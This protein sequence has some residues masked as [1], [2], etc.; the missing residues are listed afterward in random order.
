MS[1]FFLCLDTRVTNLILEI[2]SQYFIQSDQKET[3]VKKEDRLIIA[4]DK[5]KS[6]R[7][8]KNLFQN[9]K[10][11]VLIIGDLIDFDVA[12]FELIIE[13]INNANFAKLKTFNGIY[14]IVVYNKS[15][16]KL[17]ILSDR[18]GFFP[19]FYY[20]KDDFL[21]I[22]SELS[23]FCKIL[24]NIKVNKKW[25]YQYMYFGFAVNESTFLDDVKRLPASSILIYDL[26]SKKNTIKDYIE[27]F[28]KKEHLLKGIESY[29]FAKEI[30]QDRIS[31]YFGSGK[32]F[33]C[34]LTGGWDGRTNIAL[35]PEGKNITAYTYGMMGSEDM[36]IASLVANK[37]NL[38]HIKI[39]FDDNVAESLPNLM[40][41]TVYRSQGLERVL[42]AYLIYVY[43]ILSDFPMIISGVGYDGLFRGHLGIA[44]QYSPFVGNTFRTGKIDLGA[45]YYCEIFQG[46]L[47]EFNNEINKC[48]SI[49]KNKFG[50]FQSTE[51]HLL[52]S[53]YISGTRYFLG[54]WKL[55]NSFSNFRAPSYDN[56]IIDVAYSIQEKHII[57]FS[58]FKS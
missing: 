50:E 55:A 45:D 42:R 20:I 7:L 26:I 3:L 31:K 21:I 54:E 46:S 56:Q 9:D 2:L 27:I 14:C 37:T 51:T 34:A 44:S 29:E 5:F 18:I 47:D 32:D 33:A 28:H 10:W 22:T 38:K 35:A 49:I 23:L 43:K 30:F 36:K 52:F 15:N 8:K 19:I 41:E 4:Y 48:Y 53:T 39:P 16:N 58:T 17:H 25:I 13:D 40:L 6:H 1:S 24:E 12:P 57:I 11:I